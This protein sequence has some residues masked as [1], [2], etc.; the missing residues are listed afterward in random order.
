MMLLGNLALDVGRFGMT[1]S[2]M[3]GTTPLLTE[4]HNCTRGCKELKNFPEHKTS[5]C[6]PVVSSL[7][8]SQPTHFVVYYRAKTIGAEFS[9]LFS[10]DKPTGVWLDSVFR[11]PESPTLLEQAKAWRRTTHNPPPPHPYFGGNNLRIATVWNGTDVW[12]HRAM[13]AR[14]TK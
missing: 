8:E 9:G 12:C 3:V 11:G 4:G 7:R 5:V 6:A 14:S 13:G 2:G 10:W 1:I